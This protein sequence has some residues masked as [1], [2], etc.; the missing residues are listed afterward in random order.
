VPLARKAKGGVAT[1]AVEKPRRF[2]TFLPSKVSLLVVPLSYGL[3]VTLTI[4]GCIAPG[5]PSG[6]VA[7]LAPDWSHTSEPRAWLEAARVAFT[8]LG[9]GTGVV[10]AYASYNK[11][12]HNIIR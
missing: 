3:L 11:Y 9:L 7:L 5:G 1:P 8:S 6:V 10:A 4:R 2:T 12:Q